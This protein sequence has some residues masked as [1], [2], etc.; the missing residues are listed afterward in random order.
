MKRKSI[1]IVFIIVICIALV[2]AIYTARDQYS[3][4]TLIKQCR[5][6]DS[7][8]QNTRVS[9][10]D[11]SFSLII[12]TNGIIAKEKVETIVSEVKSLLLKEENLNRILSKYKDNEYKPEINIIINFNN[13]ASNDL[14]YS[15]RYYK[16]PDRTD[17][18]D[19]YQTWTV[20]DYNN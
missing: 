11:F 9:E 2:G 17:M 18:V 3:Y 8:I 12:S 14:L 20:L 10:R 13:D 19:N 4:E 7:S 1:I 15:A 16:E 5:N 6:I